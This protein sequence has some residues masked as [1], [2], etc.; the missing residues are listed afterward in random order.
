[1]NIGQVTSP[2]AAQRRARPNRGGEN[3]DDRSMSTPGA[4]CTLSIWLLTGLATDLRH[5][6]YVSFALV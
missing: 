4:I 5:L 1:V 3:G 6:T 2:A